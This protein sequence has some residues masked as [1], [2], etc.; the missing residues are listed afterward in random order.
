MGRQSFLSPVYLDWILS[1]QSNIRRETVAYRRCRT[2][3]NCRSR[4]T[5]TVTEP[6]QF[7]WQGDSNRLLAIRGVR[8]GYVRELT[9]D[10]QGRLK[11]EKMKHPKGSGSIEYEYAGESMLP[12]TAKSD[13][14]FYDKAQRTVQFEASQRTPAAR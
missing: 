8:S 13:D 6:L 7:T 1:V 4:R 10:K 2:P 11:S 12:F 3:R 9:Y 14:N 5:A